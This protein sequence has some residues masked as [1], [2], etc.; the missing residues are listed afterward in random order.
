MEDL[1]GMGVEVR[2]VLAESSGEESTGD[3]T[4]RGSAP[5]TSISKTA[6]TAHSA[7]WRWNGW[8]AGPSEPFMR[9]SPAMTWL[10]RMESRSRKAGRRGGR[11]VTGPG[12]SWG[13]W[14]PWESQ[15]VQD[16][17][18]LFPLLAFQSRT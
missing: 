14:G 12:E 1:A 7:A 17:S 10:L 9:D 6:F 2:R 4:S 3:R 11:R 5:P 8:G 13:W 16:S 18:S 15:G